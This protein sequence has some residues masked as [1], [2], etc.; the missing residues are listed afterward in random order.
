M[1]KS[2]LL[3]VTSL[4]LTGCLF[5]GTYPT[6]YHLDLSSV[7]S[8]MSYTQKYDAFHTAV[9]VQGL[10]NRDAPRIFLTCQS[11]DDLWLGRLVEPDGL[12]ENWPVYEVSGLDELIELFEDEIDGVILYDG[13]SA[14]GVISTSLVATTA[15]AIENAIAVR[16]DYTPGSMYNYL[17]NDTSGPQFAVIEDLTD[18]FKSSGGYDRLVYDTSITVPYG[19]GALGNLKYLENTFTSPVT[20]DKF[21]AEFV[22]DDDLGSRVNRIGALGYE[23]I[24]AVSNRDFESDFTNWRTF[25]VGGSEAVFS[26]SAD[27]FSGTKAASLN[28]T[29]AS[30]GDH[31]LD[32]DTA[33]LAVSYQDILKVSFAAKKISTG[34]TRLQLTVAEYDASGNY[35][36]SYSDE[37][38]NPVTTGYDKFELKCSIKN[39]QTTQVNIG[40]RVT[41]SSGVKTT[42]NYLIDD[43]VAIAN[44]L[45]TVS[46]NGFESDFTDWRY[47]A[48]S[49]AAANF[50][51]STDSY[52]GSKAASIE[53][54]TG[55]GDHGLDRDS[56]RLSVSAEDTLTI[57]FASKKISGAN[58]Y[59]MLN[60]SEFDS[61][62]TYLGNYTQE[63]FAPSSS[64][65]VY[66]HQHHIA[67]S[68]TAYVNI[69]FR[70]TDASLARIQGEYLI[71]DV[72]VNVESHPVLWDSTSVT[73]SS[74]SPDISGY[75]IANA[76]TGDDYSSKTIFQSGNDRL[77]TV[78]WSCSSDVTLYS[79]YFMLEHDNSATY[80]RAVNHFTLKAD[81][82]NSSKVWQTS[83]AS[84][85]SAKCD[86]YI[87]AVENYLSQGLCDPTTLSYTLDLW[88]CSSSISLKNQLSNLDYAIMKKGF[89]FELSPWGDEAPNDDTSQTVGTDLDT[90]KTIIDECNTQTG[91]TEMIKVCGF[92][93]W[94][95]KYTSEVG[96]SHDPVP[97][98]WEF[99][100]L[101]SA[102]NAYMEGDALSLSY[103]SNCSFYNGLNPAVKARR[104]IQNP[105]P[106]YDDMVSRGL[107]D[108]NGNV[109]AG[110][111][112]LMYMGDYDQA[113]WTLYWLAGDRY[114][115][116]NRG[117]LA[118]S[119]ALTPNTSDRVSVAYEYMYRNKT[120]RDYF[121]AGDSGAGYLNPGLL[122]GTRA[123]SYY[124]SAVSI[125]QKHCKEYYRQWDYSITGWLLNG[126]APTM[127]TTDAANYQC[128]SPDGI[129][130]GID[131]NTSYQF[132]S[133]NSPAITR[134]GP[135][136][137]DELSD[138][139][140]YSSG[141]HFAW[142]RTILYS[143]TGLKTLQDSCA[144]SG[145]NH[146][147]LDAYTFYYLLR[148][149][150]G[151]NNNYRAT[152][153]N[154]TVPRVLANGDT[155]NAT[156]TVRNDGWDTWSESNNYR[157]SYAIVPKGTEPD[158]SDYDAN[159]RFY[160]T[161]T[162]APGESY[163][164]SVSIDSP[165]TNGN[166]DIYIDMVRDGVT[167]FRSANN[168]EWRGDVIVATD[169][170]D[171]DTDGD[172]FSDMQEIRRETLYWHPD[173]DPREE[174]V[175]GNNEYLTDGQ[176]VVAAD[177]ESF[178]YM[179]G[180]GNL[181]VYKGSSPANNQGLIW[182]SDSSDTTDDYYLKMQNDGNL[183]I[184]RGVY[185]QNLGVLWTSYTSDAT[186][187][188]YLTLTT[189]GVLKAYMGTV[190]SGE[191]V[192][193]SDDDKI[194]LF[195]GEYL[196]DNYYETSTKSKSFV[197]M[198]DDGNLVVYEGSSPY[199]IQGVIWNSDSAGTTDDYYLKMQDDGN[200]V[201]YKGTPPSGNNG[202][203]WQSNTSGT[204][205]DYYLTLSDSGILRIYNGTLRD[206]I[207]IWDSK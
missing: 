145:N 156:V 28:V 174:V 27:A 201:I 98:E 36:S 76:F 187:T 12:C 189:D 71:D 154:D 138:M 144:S 100:E 77:Y 188:Y 120:D 128:F 118:C 137:P 88:G 69:A 16:K 123:P 13:D 200:L 115:D 24:V 163:D 85:G 205:G 127:T 47:F 43:V 121:I 172:G 63:L 181:A 131:T 7:T 21:R 124:P 196:E 173:D 95:Q 171:I 102:Y 89:C 75:G 14:D 140:N 54:T 74:S 126:N 199:D 130:M 202:V 48:V 119:W 136:N 18:K 82:V 186:D 110:N 150:L 53:V 153:V 94:D 80:D 129:G 29:D 180:D 56:S 90:F 33:K 41:D 2:W 116:S 125:W 109:V 164:F 170:D 165:T 169:Q 40:F 175:I 3:L 103:V 101:L 51:I 114:D 105:A 93:N 207:L 8:T 26:I 132:L 143:P 112:I 9:C 142:Y 158:G 45:L 159:G 25:A 146:Q 70:I 23:D 134:S 62:G 176:Y 117:N 72:Q 5:A 203:P 35:L 22:A 166:Y 87:W 147:F 113:S 31:G 67:N 194:V 133:G 73:V 204:T 32:R 97:T 141:V 149:Y 191:K 44:P 30:S 99:A 15:A 64:Y 10:V 68:D 162:V 96:G 55:G 37:L 19:G 198:Q 190:G 107:I 52:S 157:L 91:K 182:S 17:V 161:G 135:D 61:S 148:Y 193:A 83:V 178:V 86:A 152:W 183:V 60:V 206:N 168:I 84:T 58:S 104:H 38:F 57:S 92:P 4:V 151:G 81:T 42:G 11:G 195:D 6:I 46:N 106:T 1:K 78:E 179:Q 49:G 139:I 108:S 184:Y 167:W 197:K 34:D 65:D 50:T 155:Y 185:P 39:S 177:S 20:A 192:W 122:H 59:V 66:T 160:I 111:Y 79:V